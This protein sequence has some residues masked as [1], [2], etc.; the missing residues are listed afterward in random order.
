MTSFALKV[1][2]LISMLFDHCG[3][4]F[5]NRVTFF[6][7]IGKVSFPIFAFQISEGYRH[8][9]N[10]K[11]YFFRLFIFA[12]ASQIPFMLFL[13]CLGSSPFYLNIFFTLFL[14]LLSITIYDKLE[15]KPLRF[16]LIVCLVILAEL[17]HCD[18]G[19]FGVTIILMFY[20]FKQKKLWMNISF[21]LA[22]IAK[23]GITYLK[24]P[25]TFDIYFIIATCL[26]LLFINLYN[27]KKG[28]NMKYLFYLF[29]PIHLMILVL[30]KF[31]V[32]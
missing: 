20:L 14:G 5:F 2:A 21:I 31:F 12:I 28:R 27:Q 9:K 18:Y 23:Y 24:T 15:N 3:Y 4:I 29:Y 6:N 11:L 32:L 22:V 16:F 8:T 10:L 7:I 1:I 19:W 25:N 26:A 17:I 13:F 30:L